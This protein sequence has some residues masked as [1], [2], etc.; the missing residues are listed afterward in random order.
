[1]PEVTKPRVAVTVLGCKV[2]QTEAESIAG[3]FSQSGYRVVDFSDEA[4]VYVIHTCT[5]TAESDKKSRNLIRRAVRQNPKAIVA[6]TGCY[7]QVSPQVV[8]GIEGVDVVIGT[9]SLNRI[10]ERVEEA[11]KQGVKVR[12]VA[13]LAKANS[14]E[15]LPEQMAGRARAFLK[16][17][18]G[19][20]QFC[21]YCIIPYARG[22]VRSRDPR[23]VVTKVEE[24]VAAGFKEVVLTGIRL[25]AYGQ[26]L[27]PKVSLAQ[28][29]ELIVKVK[30]LCRLRISSVDPHDFTPELE[31]VITGYPK[32][33][34][35]YHIPLQSGDDTILARMGRRYSSGEFLDLI[36]RL[37]EK[38]PFAAFTTDV[39]VGFPGETD[40]HFANTKKAIREAGFMG[41]HV[42]KYSPRKGTPAADYPDQID[43]PL[44]SARS[45]EVM[46]LA[47]RLFADYARQFL[48]K[49]AEV[50]V[51]HQDGDGLWEGHTPN[52]LLVK[53]PSD[54]ELSNKIV[55]AR[56]V[57]IGN[58]CV[59]AEGFE[60]MINE[61]LITE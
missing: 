9:G 34:P 47:E 54:Q 37:R 28:L 14:F 48:D 7:S 60:K 39:M 55:T 46:E 6:V 21:T 58:N 36:S 61:C 13:D 29:I 35:H 4:D 45:K 59:Y 32:I 27:E 15:N 20:R 26:D 56:I 3:M 18:E 24:F 10:V 53:F 16:V 41:V 11:R 33:C 57:K 51:E 12:E 49:E 31:S 19:C 40:H 25:G 2:N 42:F 30:G 44:K 1:V 22:P 52:Y 17:Q 8:E 43:P 50:L 5:V 38:R 23:E